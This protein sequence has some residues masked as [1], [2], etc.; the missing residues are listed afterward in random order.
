M[1][2]RFTS[3]GR[4]RGSK[5]GGAAFVLAVCEEMQNGK[6]GKRCNGR[7]LMYFPVVALGKV[8]DDGWGGVEIRLG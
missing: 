3:E 8:E 7:Q 2:Q 4:K 5:S 6:E 1:S